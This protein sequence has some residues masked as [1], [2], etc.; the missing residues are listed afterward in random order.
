MAMKTTRF[1]AAAMAAVLLAGCST[2]ASRIRSSPDA[3]A[4]L[5][6]DEQAL[7]KAGRIA[8]GFD[9]EAVTL[10]LGAPDRKVTYTSAGGRFEVWHYIEYQDY[11][12]MIY[13]GPYR[14]FW[15]WRGMYGW[16]PGPYGL[17]PYYYGYPGQV[18]DRIRVTFDRNGRVESIQEEK[19]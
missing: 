10:A 5:N 8:V 15:G 13:V 16:G 14:R 11:D 7:V 2:P 17:P 9:M 4:R 3:F 6:P 12:G 1:F 18:Y 19:P